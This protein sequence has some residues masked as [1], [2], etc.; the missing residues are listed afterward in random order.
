MVS[1]FPTTMKTDVKIKE[2]H[3]T[4]PSALEGSV[5]DEPVIFFAPVLADDV[6]FIFEVLMDDES[7]DL[8]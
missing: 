6:L 2:L 3:N 4:I 7:V 1:K 5:T 8:P